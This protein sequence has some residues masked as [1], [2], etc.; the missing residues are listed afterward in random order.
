M[1][2][3]CRAWALAGAVVVPS[4]AW[5]A[6]TLK[7][8]SEGTDA[9]GVKH[10]A[11]LALDGDLATAWA[12]GDMGAGE[13][14]WI[15]LRFDKPT[16]ISGLSLWAGDLRE[17]ERSA[18]GSP[19]PRTFTV[20]LETDA[21]PVS[22]VGAVPDIRA[23]GIQRVDVVVQGVAKSLRVTVD[24]VW[25]GYA[26]NDCYIAEIA[27]NFTEA[28]PEQVKAFRDWVASDA[29]KKAAEKHLDEVKATFE[30]IVSA[31]FGDMDA[32]RKLMDWSAN[33]APY[34]AEKVKRDVPLGWR[35][36]AL[37]PDDVA[38][39]ALLK[40][41]DAN[42]IPALQLAAMRLRGKPAREL[43]DKVAYF[44]A[45]TELH[46]GPRRNLP[47]WG[48]PG[49]EKG[50]LQGFEEP[51]AIAQG[52]FGDLYVADVANNRVSVFA[53]DGTTRAVLGLGKP[54]VTDGWLGKRRRYYVAGAEASTEEG[55]FTQPLDVRVSSS[56][57][58][59][60]LSVL[61]AA[62]RVQV[63]GPDGA[64]V[65][66][67]TVRPTEPYSPGVG[68]EGHLLTVGGR[69]V[70][71]WGNEA[72]VTDAAGEEIARWTVEDGAP[73]DAEVLSSSKLLLGFRSGAVAYGLD[74]FRHGTVVGTDALPAGFEA[75]DLAWDEKHKLWAVTDNGWLVKYKKPG[76]V[77]WQVSWSEQSVNVPRFAVF[78]GMLHVTSEGRILR[79]DALELRDA[80]E[81]ADE[82]G[83]P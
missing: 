26:T 49:W 15:E 60:T 74:G 13:G 55:G 40:I 14:S 41:K 25:P 48:A 38:I 80:A 17:L 21:G 65:R 50:A 7:A 2:A 22:A 36:Q 59:D 72:I 11:S 75:F 46:A 39:E 51:L 81:Q 12:E 16:A 70:V 52:A 79:L 43:L 3:V 18:K 10:P 53:P 6:T 77:D 20:T 8:S 83:A 33:G 4:T 54:N 32:L 78:D 44:E 28:E 35:V 62:G 58:G 24:E 19:R 66:S 9:D 1:R 5:S 76:V 69:V 82:E 64:L 67:F 47:T 27:L 45:W 34:V 42:A 31:E 57:D 29:T 56:K 68:G 73:I 30:S 61:D 63:F 23:K 37:P 71:L